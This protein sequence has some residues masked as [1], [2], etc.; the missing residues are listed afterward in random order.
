MHA[1]YLEARTLVAQCA[2]LDPAAFIRL[3]DGIG[4]LNEGAYFYCM[5]L[6]N[7]ITRRPFISEAGFIGLVPMDAAE[8]DLLAVVHVA[9]VPFVLRAREGDK[10]GWVLIGEAYVDGLMDGEVLASGT[11][12]PKDCRSIK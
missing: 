10:N 8:G 5:N 9:R 7:Q 12:E 3:V 11:G 6:S 2:S 4:S 1:S